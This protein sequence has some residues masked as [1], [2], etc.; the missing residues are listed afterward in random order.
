[1]C[2]TELSS[3]GHRSRRSQTTSSPSNGIESTDRYPS[4]RDLPAPRFSFNGAL[5]VSAA[6]FKFLSLPHC[7]GR[8][9][10]AFQIVVTY[11]HTAI[12]GTSVTV[13]SSISPEI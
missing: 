12:D 3:H 1:M 10:I 6:A 11:T 5:T 13:F 7:I 9:E 8:T 4:M 2:D